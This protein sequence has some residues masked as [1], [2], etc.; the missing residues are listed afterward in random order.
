[1]NE[2]AVNLV[3]EEDIETDKK[4]ETSIIYEGF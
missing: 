1:M 3:T 4:K 2:E